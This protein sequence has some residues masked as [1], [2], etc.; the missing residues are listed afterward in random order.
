L[1]LWRNEKRAVSISVGKCRKKTVVADIKPRQAEESLQV[2]KK[3]G[4]W[5]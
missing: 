3:L 4:S 1:A 2:V 5:A